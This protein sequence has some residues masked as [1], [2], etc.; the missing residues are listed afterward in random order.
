VAK[1]QAVLKE[2]PLPKVTKK[3]RKQSSESS[4][5]D[6]S[7]SSDSEDEKKKPK[8]KVGGLALPKQSDRTIE[9]KGPVQAPS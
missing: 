7:E 8:K 6:G 1:A 4:S 3:V 5:N 9:P 2:D